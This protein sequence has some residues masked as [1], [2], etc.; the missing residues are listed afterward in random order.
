MASRIKKLPSSATATM[1]RER[2]IALWDSAHFTTIH[3][4]HPG[5]PTTKDPVRVVL[6]SLIAPDRHFS[7]VGEDCDAAV[8][9]ALVRNTGLRAIEAG[10][11]GALARLENALHDLNVTLWLQKDDLDDDIPF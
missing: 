11:A 1:L 5:R 2:D 4:A 3:S 10:L 8:Q 7:G 6:I 9:D